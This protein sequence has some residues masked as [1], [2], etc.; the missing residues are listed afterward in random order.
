MTTADRLNRSSICIALSNAAG[1]YAHDYDA[2]SAEGIEVTEC[3]R[4]TRGNERLSFWR[5]FINASD[6]DAL[7]AQAARAISRASTDMGLV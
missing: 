1:F 3:R 2:P 5:A 4:Q 7:P 6:R